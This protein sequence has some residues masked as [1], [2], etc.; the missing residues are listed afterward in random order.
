MIALSDPAWT[1]LAADVVSEKLRGTYFSR[2]LF[3]IGILSM[4]AFL[5]GGFIL[6]LFPKESQAGFVIVFTTGIILGLLATGIMAKVREPKARSHD[7]H[8]FKDFTREWHG[9][10]G[11]F[12][13][14]SCVFNF[15][16]MLSS[17]FFTAYMLNDLKM[18]YS[19]FVIANALSF[20]AKVF[21]QSAFGPMT[22]RDG[23]KPVAM[24]CVFGTG[25]IPLVFLFL[26]TGNLWLLIPA[27]ILSGI[28][29]A[30]VEL[31]TFNLLL[32]VSDK[33]DRPFQ[34][35]EYNV[36]TSIPMVIAPIA[37]GFLADRASLFGLAGIPLVFGVSMVL[38]FL[39]AGL[40]IPLPERRGPANIPVWAV[41]REFMGVFSAKGVHR[42]VISVKKWVSAK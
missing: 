11:W 27:Q 10:F 14:F 5:S 36:I 8:S 42:Q 38:R 12:L 1:S 2:R 19:L 17:P 22:D 29:W 32:D 7:L 25:L 39:S 6:D 24:I 37:G 35:A 23:D 26:H 28:V 33:N 9:D 31:T 20:I 3:V 21:S 4:L 16:Y 13:L 15:A 18:S 30:G 41:M 40:L 34:I